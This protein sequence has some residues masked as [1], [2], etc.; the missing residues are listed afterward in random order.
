MTLFDYVRSASSS[1]FTV[2]F[3]SQDD[4][5]SWDPISSSIRLSLVAEVRLTEHH[6]SIGRRQTLLEVSAKELTIL[7][8]EYEIEECLFGQD[9][10]LRMIRF[11]VLGGSKYQGLLNNGSIDLRK[12]T[13]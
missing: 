2:T 6:N 12:A 13:P 9:S 4:E 10:D 7:L 3:S 11:H 8:E 5:N 1:R